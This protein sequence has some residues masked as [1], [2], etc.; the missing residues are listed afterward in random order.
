M[1]AVASKRYDVY[2]KFKKFVQQ[3]DKRDMDAICKG[4]EGVFKLQAQQEFMREYMR[5]YPAWRSL[6]LYHEIGSGKTCTA[7]TMCREYL[8][9]YPKNKV[10]VILPARLRT[11]FVDELL[12]ACGGGLKKKDIAKKYEFYSFERLKKEAM[13]AV[14]AKKFPAWL[15]G[16]TKDRLLIVDEVHNLLSDK[17]DSKAM[18][19]AIAPSMTMKKGVKGMNTI[20]FRVLTK[21]ADP[22][23]KLVL[24]TATPI[25]DNLMQL[26]ELAMVMSPEAQLPEKDDKLTVG[27]IAEQLRGKVSYFPGTSAHAYPT[28]TY[29]YHKIPFSATQD[30]VTQ[31]LQA[32]E[33]DDDDYQESF[34]AK[35]RQASIACLPKN[36]KV[37]DNLKTVLENMEEYSPKVKALVEEIERL[38]GKHLVYSNFVVAGL[39]VVEGALRKR[40][41]RALGEDGGKKGKVYAV[42]DGSVTDSGKQTI[43]AVV[44]AK[45]NLFGDKVRVILGSPSVKE[46][47]SFKHIQHM[48]M[49]DP[50]WNQSAKAQVEGRAVRFCSHVDIDEKKH[51]PLKREVIMHIYQ[52]VPR[53]GG[54]VTTSCDQMIYEVI[55]ERKK[56]MVAAGEAMLKRVAIDHYLFRKMYAAENMP[57]PTTPG[58]GMSDLGLDEAVKKISLK[59]RNEEKQK[60]STCPKPR[61]PDPIKG[62]EAGFFMKKNNQGFEC[63]YKQSKGAAAAA[64]AKA[65]KPDKAPKA[66]GATS[67]CPAPRR[68]VD[69]KCADGYI[70]KKN[71]KGVDC[72]YKQVKAKAK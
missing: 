72:C 42:W 9:K 41:W 27:M 10:Q 46:G 17:Y 18:K 19:A 52:S 28:L 59:G 64:Q 12:S 15:K 2:K 38:P 36:R 5:T 43:K 51:A 8:A 25:F 44:N 33:K 13:E 6:L 70:M 1:K 45:D 50:V 61:R 21:F 54:L 71:A 62:C 53:E 69:G 55:I 32:K 47:V 31:L 65:A 49:L 57:S 16:F 22:S 67:S 14:A 23:C 34:M 30:E 63:C 66:T 56:K 68:P 35:Q 29:E 4:E 40:G 11:N 24:M 39:D 20:L 26:R 48:H 58:T 3:K 37:S 7:I 60:R